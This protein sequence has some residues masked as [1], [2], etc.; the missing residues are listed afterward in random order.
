MNNTYLTCILILILTSIGF[1]QEIVLQGKITDTDNKTLP[2]VNIG[3]PDKNTGTVSNENG[4]Y[5]LKIPSTIKDSDTVVFSYI[6]YKT[7][8]KPISELKNLKRNSI[9]MEI[10]ENQLAEVVLETKKFKYKKLGRTNK[11]LGFMHFNYYTAKEKEVDDRLSKEIGM[12]FKLK[13]NC[14]L[15]KFN[16]AI[17]T[18]EFEKLKL[19][20]NIYSLVDGEPQDLLI[21]ENIIIKLNNEETGWKSI[22]LNSYNIYLEEEIE[23][24]LVTLQ[25]I[26]SEKSESDS[27]FFAIPASKSPFHKIYSRQKAMDKWK[28]QTGSLSMYLDAKCSS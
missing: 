13:K 25:W 3:I 9:Q 28:S 24:F 1:S 8:K 12:N 5:L 4:E 17:S 16:F 7:I 20:V 22:D 11:G 21:K 15:E 27:K 23:E 19:R 26:E 6:G 10:E 14:R 18:N 2:F